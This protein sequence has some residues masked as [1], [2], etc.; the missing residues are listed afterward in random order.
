[1]LFQS[2]SKKE[3]SIISK[4]IVFHCFRNGPIE[5]IHADGRISQDEMRLIM[6]A[7]VTELATVIDGFSNA[8]GPYIK[9]ENFLRLELMKLWDEPDW[10]YVKKTNNQ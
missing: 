1:M 7:A 2:L 5:D 3:I 6:Q 9:K 8:R 4:F 10:S